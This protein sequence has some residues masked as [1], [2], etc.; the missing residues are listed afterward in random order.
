MLSL[1]DKLNYLIIFCCCVIVS[2]HGSGKGKHRYYF[3]DV[4][5]DVPWLFEGRNTLEHSARTYTIRA[6]E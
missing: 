3:I 4:V 2:V 1:K 6:I 5:I